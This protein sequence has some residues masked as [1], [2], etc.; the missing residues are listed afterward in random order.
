MRSPSEEKAA[1]RRAAFFLPL[2]TL[3]VFRRAACEGAG[4]RDE[5][6]TFS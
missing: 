3:G 6:A 1:L 2:K 4:R 5:D